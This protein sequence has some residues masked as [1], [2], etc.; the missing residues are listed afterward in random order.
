MPRPSQPLIN[1]KVAVATALA[2]IDTEG[3]GA[4]SLP[5][6]ARE[7]GVR[8][9]SL[10]HHFEDRAEILEE[11]AQSIVLET[12]IPRKPSGDDWMNWFVAL[13]MNF[14]RVI[15]RHGNA[16]PILLEFL[17]R[18]MLSPL[19]DDAAEFL[20][21][22]GVATGLHVLILDGLEKLTLG[23]AVTEAMRR[24]ARRGRIFGHVDPASQPALAQAVKA[25]ELTAADLFAE[26]IRAF[27]L[28]VTT[29]PPAGGR[30]QDGE[31]G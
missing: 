24:P 21:Q 25:N 15:L 30:G 3:L 26:T 28:G 20:T 10:Y 11:V 4:F 8:A 31:D 27:L 2:I 17:P 7:L 22:A 12:V 14:R 6:L 16:A 5:R 29:A 23:A 9:P 19:Y 13:A 1:R 18:D